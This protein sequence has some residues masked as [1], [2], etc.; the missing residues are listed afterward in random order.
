M[1]TYK[2]H[3]DHS[4]WME[5]RWS[6]MILCTLAKRREE[7]YE[8]VTGEPLDRHGHFLCCVDF[9][10]YYCYFINILC[11]TTLRTTSFHL[12]LPQ[13]G[14]DGTS[15]QDCGSPIFLYT[16]SECVLEYR[17]WKWTIVTTLF[18]YLDLW[19]KSWGWTG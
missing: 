13:S 6:K 19:I 14:T 3:A 7:N 5:K 8:I 12:Y 1:K 9:G 16:H 11:W 2:Y 4:L 15:I 18:L 10:L 17:N